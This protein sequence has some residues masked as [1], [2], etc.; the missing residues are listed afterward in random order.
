MC[1]FIF[2]II[3]I[4]FSLFHCLLNC[5]FYRMVLCIYCSHVC[6]YPRQISQFIVET[7]KN[8]LILSYIHIT[9]NANKSISITNVRTR[10]IFTN[11]LGRQ[12]QANVLA[13]KFHL[14]SSTIKTTFIVF[15][16]CTSI[17]SLLRRHSLA[18]IAC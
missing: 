13:R 12:M 2:I 11:L 10:K 4:I 7:I 18:F 5:R 9:Y 1:V 17:S 3:T 14:Y 8:Y 6:S 15:F 16:S